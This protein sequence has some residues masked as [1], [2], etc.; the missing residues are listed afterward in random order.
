M[1]RLLV[2]LLHS[3]V[4]IPLYTHPLHALN[5]SPIVKQISSV[6]VA[7]SSELLM[8]LY[9]IAGVW[10][11]KLSISRE[12]KHSRWLGTIS[13]VTVSSYILEKEVLLLV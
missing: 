11:L 6:F 2:W 4:H 8:N 12:V 13:I 5:P 9:S 10:V 3:S 1:D 7:S